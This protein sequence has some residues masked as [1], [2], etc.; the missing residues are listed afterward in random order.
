MSHVCGLE[1]KIIKKPIVPKLVYTFNGIPI[2]IPTVCLSVCLSVCLYISEVVRL[3][4]NSHGNGQTQEQAD[5]MEGQRGRLTGPVSLMLTLLGSQTIIVRK[6]RKQRLETA[7]HI[8]PQ[9]RAE[10]N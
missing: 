4:L 8:H 10:E 2:K 7:G 5:A 9:S 6:S 1:D 3:I